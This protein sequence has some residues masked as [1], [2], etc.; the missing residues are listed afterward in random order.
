M[1]KVQSEEMFCRSIW[2]GYLVERRYDI[3]EEVVAENISVIGTGA[4]EVSRNM[5]E[6]AAAMS[7]ESREWNVRFIIKDQWYQTT[8]LSDTHS[9]VMGE[10]VVREDA[11]DGILYDLR[12]RFTMVLVRQGDSWKL[13]HI[14]QSVPDCNQTADEFFPHHIVEKNE[15]QVI[16]S[17]RHDGLTGLLNRLYLKQTVNRFIVEQPAGILLMMDIDKFK[18]LNDS[19]GHPF[20]DSI[21]IALSQSLQAVFGQAVA[22]RI[23]GDEFVVYLPGIENREQAEPYLQRFREDW[24]ERQ[25][26]LKLPQEITVSMGCSRCPEH[27]SNYDELW[28]CADQ[29]LYQAKEN[30][31]G[32]VWY[33]FY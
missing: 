2:H 16:Y 27:G 15:R 19:F 9:L 22:G 7:Y 17:L 24:K 6:F 31:G 13:C 3:L 20:G 30:G 1:G 33:L 18:Q 32:Q 21:L 12:F 29:A 8:R 26:P 10:I 5:E 11:E 23:G 14:H 4:H 28:K 25:Q